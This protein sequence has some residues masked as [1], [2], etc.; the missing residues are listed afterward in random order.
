MILN[1][2]RLL[3]FVLKSFIKQTYKTLIEHPLSS[4]IINKCFFLVKS[5][6]LSYIH[7]RNNTGFN[8]LFISDFFYWEVYEILHFRLINRTLLR[9]SNLRIFIH[10]SQI[11]P[12]RHFSLFNNFFIQILAGFINTFDITT[13]PLC[14]NITNVADYILAFFTFVRVFWDILAN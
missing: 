11:N 8:V 13:S 9:Q 14:I 5:S 7:L 10:R 1:I 3:F 6:F 12:S 4:I 2:S